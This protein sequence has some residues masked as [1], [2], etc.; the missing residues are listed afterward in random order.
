M[1]TPPQRASVITDTGSTILAFPCSG[2]NNCGKHTDQPFAALQSSTL[3]HVTCDAKQHFRCQTCHEDKDV[4]KISQSYMEGSSW[5]ATVVDDVLYL[6]DE[7]SANDSEM[8][9]RF[10]TRFKF[11]CQYGETGLFITQVAD[12]IM[13]LGNNGKYNSEHVSGRINDQWK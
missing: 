13:G 10:G 2:C 8:R 3:E 5:S 6:G 4:C 12:G 7:A 9:T 1:G 11:G